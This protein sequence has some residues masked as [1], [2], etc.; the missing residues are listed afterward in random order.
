MAESTL[1]VS[2]D[3]AN[4]NPIITF[5]SRIHELKPTATALRTPT[6]LK[7]NPP[8]EMSQGEILVQAQAALNSA[9]GLV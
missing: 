8:C 6:R 9:T 2:V 3:S 1:E 4:T 7:A 5:R